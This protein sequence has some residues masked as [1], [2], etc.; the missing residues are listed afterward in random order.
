MKITGG[1]AG[2]IPV[3]VLKG[4]RTRPTTDRIRESLFGSLRDRIPDAAV[5][6]LFAGS[7]ALGL[8][9]ASRGAARVDFVEKHG[10]TCRLIEKNA[11]KV[12]K[13]G[14]TAALRVH[15]L[16]SFRYLKTPGLGQVD[17]VFA[18]PPYALLEPNGAYA[19]LLG[20]VANSGVL[21]KSGL[22][23]VEASSRL[24]LPDLSEWKVLKSKNYGSSTLTLW[25]PAP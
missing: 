11:A 7:G 19:Q 8:E 9:A 10:G 20:A 25:V 5:L 14:S 1:V 22:L 17:L 18:D 6:D 3:E 2:G 15:V 12:T 4:N 13:A 24:Q 23:V 21:A 16:D